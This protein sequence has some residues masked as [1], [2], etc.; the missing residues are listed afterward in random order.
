MCRGDRK[1]AVMRRRG[2]QLSATLLIMLVF[3][4]SLASTGSPAS[5][6]GRPSAAPTMVAGYDQG[7]SPDF[8]QIVYM[9]RDSEWIPDLHVCRS[10]TSVRLRMW[11]T[12]KNKVWFFDSPSPLSYWTP[13]D[14]AGESYKVQ[15][16]RKGVRRVFAARSQTPKLTLE[17]GVGVVLNAFPFQ[18][19]L[20]QDAFEQAAWRAA[21]LSVTT[22]Q[23]KAP[24][25]VASVLGARSPT[26][27]AVLTCVASAYNVYNLGSSTS[28]AN[29]LAAALGLRGEAA[30]CATA[31]DKAAQ[32]APDESLVL[33]SADLERTTLRLKWQRVASKWLRIAARSPL[34][35]K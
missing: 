33:T 2:L 28:P 18:L 13:A 11:N 5:A 12:S 14:D 8:P 4:G 27:K 31:I 15:L 7:C 9:Y 29:D 26:R 17:P 10:T 3:T 1:K 19:R 20:H 30:K 22:L 23:K 21:A 6:A 25:W 32:R 34:A 24:G 16:F 35:R